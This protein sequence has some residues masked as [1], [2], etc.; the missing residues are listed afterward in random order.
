MLMLSSLSSFLVTSVIR[1]YLFVTLVS[2]CILSLP[3][4]PALQWKACLTD[5]DSVFVFYLLNKIQGCSSVPNFT[6]D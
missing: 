6:T 5:L 1:R 3:L 4:S 2:P